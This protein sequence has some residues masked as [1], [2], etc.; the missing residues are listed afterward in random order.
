MSK[1]KL[2]DHQSNPQLFNIV[3][4]VALAHGLKMPKIAIVE[5]D[6]PNAFA[7]GRNIDNS[8]IAFT[9]GILKKMDREMLQGVAAHELS[10]IKNRD[11]MVATFAA[12]TAGIIA[13]ICDII[14]RIFLYS[15][16]SRRD[17]NSKGNP[18]TALALLLVVI[19]TPIAAS[20]LQASLSRKRESLADLSAIEMT[21]N[22]AGLRRA[23]EVLRDDNTVVDARSNAVAHLYIES[24]IA[25]KKFNFFATHPPIEERIKVLEDLEK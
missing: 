11:T 14:T 23:L 6:A 19:L 2:V 7:T 22:P 20:L 1:A 12:V 8:I 17:S 15:S 18:F 24:P 4:E 5:D 21:R 10:H 25:K 16:S 3:E 9:T 13:L